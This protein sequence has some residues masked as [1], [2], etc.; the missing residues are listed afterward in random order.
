[1][2]VNLTIIRFKYATIT[3]NSAHTANQLCVGLSTQR[4]FDAT[5]IHAQNYTLQ[6][7]LR[8]KKKLMRSVGLFR[9]FHIYLYYREQCQLS[10]VFCVCMKKKKICKQ[11]RNDSVIDQYQLPPF[12][13]R[14]CFCISNVYF[15]QRFFF[16]HF[17]L[18]FSLRFVKK[19]RKNRCGCGRM[20]ANKRRRERHLKINTTERK[21]KTIER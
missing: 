15:V 19:K 4:H 16:F 17:A 9:I 5:K 8:R 18:S 13:R 3:L 10:S 2:N 1:M 12:M 6:I 14:T 11:K 20:R 21:R 7:E